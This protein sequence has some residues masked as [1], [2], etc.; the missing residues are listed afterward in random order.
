MTSPSLA[1]Q[2][3]ILLLLTLYYNATFTPSAAGATTIDVAANKFTDG[4]GNQ[5]L[6]TSD[7]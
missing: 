1:A 6:A 7:A 2:Y 3:P 4:A 5:N